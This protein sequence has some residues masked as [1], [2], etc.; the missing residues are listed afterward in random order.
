MTGR[1]ALGVKAIRGVAVARDSVATRVWPISPRPPKYSYAK[2]GVSTNSMGN[3]A[4]H[5]APQL[6]VRLYGARRCQAYNRPADEPNLLSLSYRSRTAT[7]E[8]CGLARHGTRC[9]GSTS[10][11]THPS[12][13]GNSCTLAP[14]V[15][16]L[17]VQ[18]TSRRMPGQPNGLT[19]EIGPYLSF[20]RQPSDSRHS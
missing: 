7:R 9:L 20:D 5:D 12:E 16:D 13:A 14:F 17:V 15:V 3:W 1:T 10:K 19:G 4:I 18:T 2:K 6:P 11:P 8:R